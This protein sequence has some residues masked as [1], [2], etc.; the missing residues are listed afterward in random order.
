[1]MATVQLTKEN[2][3]EVLSSNDM[4]LIDF[5]ASWCGP[6]QVFGPIFEAASERHPDIVFAKV[7]T[8]AQQE[9]AR[10]FGIR[11]IPMLMI[12]RAQVVVYAQ[13]G[14]VPGEALE[15]LVDRTL[16]L[17]MDEVDRQMEAHLTTQGAS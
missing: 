13:P 17:D 7:D 2:L 5:W 6:C 12:V 9:L 3:D 15:E 14:A 10:S 1:M 16:K 4:V 8:E 11:S